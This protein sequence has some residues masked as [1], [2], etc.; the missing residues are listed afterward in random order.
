ME[1]QTWFV[2]ETSHLLRID[3]P[4]ATAFIANS[5][6]FDHATQM[7]ED[8][9]NPAFI[10]DEIHELAGKRYTKKKSNTERP[11]AALDCASIYLQLKLSLPS[12]QDFL[13]H[14]DVSRAC[15]D[16]VS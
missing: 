13:G 14:I 7:A 1:T 8:L 11:I 12:L 5:G 9:L 2:Q 15:Y 6:F 10:L 4:L 3:C 16:A